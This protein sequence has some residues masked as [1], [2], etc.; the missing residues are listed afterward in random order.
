MKPPAATASSAAPDGAAR[1]ERELVE[2]PPQSPASMRRSRQPPEDAVGADV[3]EA[4][5]VHAHVR[6]V[7]RHALHGARSTQLE[8]RR[9]SR[10]VELQQRGAELEALRPLGPSARLIAPL[11]REDRRAVRRPPAILNRTDLHRRQVEHARNRRQQVARRAR[12]IDVDGHFRNPLTR[13]QV[14]SRRGHS[15]SAASCC[16]RPT[17]C[18]PFRNTCSSAGTPALRSARK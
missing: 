10:R 8:K 16:A 9:V 6:Q 18:G 7:R 11:H 3:V 1:L 2:A 17:P 5:I 14:A 4:V 13:S 15:A 12:A